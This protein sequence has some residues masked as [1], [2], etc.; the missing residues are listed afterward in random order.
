MRQ[1][2]PQKYGK[3]IVASLRLI[4]TEEGL[5]GFWRGNGANV[6]RV[7][8]VYALKF[9]FNDTF[10]GMV[11]SKEQSIKEL[12]PWQLMLS[13]S[14]AGLFQA[15][16][17]FPLEFIRTRLSL[18]AGIEGSESYKGIID[19]AVKVTR[20]EGIRGLY[21]GLGPTMVSGTPYVGLQMTAYELVKRFLGKV[22]GCEDHLPL[23]LSLTAGASAGIF[24]QTITFPGDTVRRRMITNGAGGKPRLYKNSLQCLISVIKIEGWTHLYSGLKTNVVRCIPGAAIQF[25]AYESVKRILGL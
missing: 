2:A 14:A 24:A 22:S 8:P 11:K 13:G 19:C 23:P 16:A 1:G 3:S 6:L 12:N 25:A 21:K 20:R 18:S 15:A 9:T 4:F 5:R 10:K 17:T 7:I